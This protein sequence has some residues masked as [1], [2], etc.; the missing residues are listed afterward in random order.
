MRIQIF[1]LINFLGV[2]FQGQLKSIF[3]AN[4]NL[5]TDYLNYKIIGD[6]L[7]LQT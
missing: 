1:S 5:P 3:Y 6:C 2:F 7:H 4:N